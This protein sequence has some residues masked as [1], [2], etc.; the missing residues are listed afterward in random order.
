MSRS[1]SFAVLTMLVA[2]LFPAVAVAQSPAVPDPIPGEVVFV[3]FAESIGI[4]VDGDL[5]DWAG[6]PT[7][8]TGDGPMSPLAPAENGSL[9]WA[10]AADAGGLYLS[11]TMPDAT[12]I[13]G[14]HG[15]AYWNEDSIEFYVNLTDDINAPTYAAGIAQ[16][17]FSPVDI[18]NT[19]PTALVVSGTNREG[20]DVSGFVF[21][22]DDGWGVEALVAWPDFFSAEHGANLGFQAHAN[23]SAG[24]DRTVKLIWSLADLDDISYNNPSV[25]GSAV[26]YELGS[27][28]EPEI[29]ERTFT[30][31]T[32]EIDKG[33]NVN[34][35]GYIPGQRKY[36]IFGNPARNPVGW[37]LTNLRGE[38]VLDG[39]TVVLGQDDKAEELVHLIDF[40]TYDEIGAYTLR[41]GDEQSW[42]FR[43]APALYAELADDAFLY[44][45]RNRS[46]IELLPEY[47]GQR[48][49]RPAGHLSDSEV[50][51]FSG[52]DPQGGT[53]DGCE[54]TLDASGGWYDAG[55]YGKY[56]VP[57]AIST[58]TLLN[59]YEANPGG[60]SDGDATIPEAGNGVPDILDEARW[61]IEWMLSMQ[62]P[63]GQPAAGLVHH[64]LHDVTWAPDAIL[65][66]T[67]YDNDNDHVNPSSGRYL[68][69]P[70]TQ[71][72]LDLAAIGAQCSRI[73][74]DLDPAF[75]A[76]CLA[77]AETAWSAAAENPGLFTGHVPGSGGGNY[78][79]NDPSDEVA[80]AATELY[81]STGDETYLNAVSD[82]IEFLNVP[83]ESAPMWWGDVAALGPMS[84]VTAGANLDVGLVAQA[85]AAVIGSADWALAVQDTFS[86]Y[87]ITLLG[88]EWGS[89]SAAL[90]NA[91]SLGL[92]HDLT[93]DPKYLTGM[94][95][96]MDY[97]L[98]RNPI[99]FSFVSGYGEAAMSAP[100]HRFWAGTA[101]LPP[102]PPGVVAGGVNAE[103]T[104]PPA[105][106]LVSALPVAMRYIDDYG[107]YSTNEV[108]IN[109]NAPLVWVASYLSQELAGERGEPRT[110][111]VP[112]PTIVTTTTA[113]TAVAEPEPAANAVKSSPWMAVLFGVGG[114]GAVLGLAV[115]ELQK[116]RNRG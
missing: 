95:E 69:P 74:A 34:Q 26:L 45:Y 86:Y 98:G 63:A 72:T 59:A 27:T 12:I 110:V 31:P 83:N 64:K 80:W 62:V 25:F 70:S 81:I 13:A 51:C 7:I 2:S 15:T 85:E 36:S 57:A 18:G 116:R 9:T 20:V 38:V 109:W 108:A 104:D 105:V 107:S 92:A 47:A 19:D 87:R 14:Q 89:N 102:V 39:E 1:F 82:S 22:T 53:W 84:M 78:D 99:N 90:N 97:L 40:T 66:P 52:P 30:V 76:R 68:M 16:M 4:T 37:E 113:P 35:H 3:P 50:T 6:F 8:T 41:V 93:G 10:V 73:W 114:L 65:P 42:S 58:W 94:I 48:W 32:A 79:D 46:G 23:G 67:E 111:A 54:Y 100:H 88:F 56:I 5:S 115:I 28:D 103:P 61:E 106:E 21:A 17:T 55:D 33:I 96:V 60:W 29:V 49:A 71:A 75:A 44:F 101:G 24:G 112:S 77:A 11:A 43:I 91:I